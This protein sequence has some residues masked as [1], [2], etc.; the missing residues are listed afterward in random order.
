M[1]NAQQFDI[2][3]LTIAIELTLIMGLYVGYKTTYLL[4]KYYG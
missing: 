2:F 3:I 4:E 1:F